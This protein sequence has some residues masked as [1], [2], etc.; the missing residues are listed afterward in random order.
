[1]KLEDKIITVKPISRPNSLGAMSDSEDH[2]GATMYTGCEKSFT[3]PRSISTGRL[4]PILDKEEQKYFAEVLNLKVEDLDFYNSNTKFWVET[5]CKITKEGISLNLKNPIENIHYR[6]LKANAEIAPSWQERH[7]KA[8]YKFALVEEGYEV[9]EINKKADKTKR[10]W[11]AFGKIEDSIQKMSD[12]LELH[13][14]SIPKDARL[15]WLQAEITKMIESTK[16]LK[17]GGLSPIEEFLAIVEDPNY[18]TRLF[19]NKAVKVGAIKKVGKHGYKLSGVSD[20]EANTA[21]NLGEM[22]DFL[23]DLENQS[24]KFTI[25]AKIEAAK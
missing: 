10:A 12:V 5:Q 20:N 1:M 13:G 23:N 25:K 19:I 4:I 9:S 15:D 11:K 24:I 18:E 7:E 22:I 3:L 14:K 6:I 21:D 2:D 17:S 16:P 8:T